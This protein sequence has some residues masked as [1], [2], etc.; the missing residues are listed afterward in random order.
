MTAITKCRTFSARLEHAVHA[1]LFVLG[2]FSST[3]VC[4]ATPVTY[5]GLDASRADLTNSKAA[6]NNFVAKLSPFAVED[7]EALGGESDPTILAG[8]PFAA[9]TD[10]DRVHTI[11]AFSVSGDHA[12]LDKGPPNQQAAG[13]NDWIQF[14]QPL[15]AFGSF[16][17]Q[18][19]DGLANT[20]TLRLTNT[21]LGTSKDVSLTL[22]PSAPF[23]NIFFFGVTD[24][25]PFD[26]VTMIETHDYDGI[27]LDDTMAGFFAPPLVSSSWSVD[28]AGDW[29]VAAN[30]TGGV[31]DEVGAAASF[32]DSISAPRTIQVD[33]LQTFG[34]LTFDNVQGYTIAGT[35]AL[36]LES[37]R[38]AWIHVNRGSHTISSQLS[39]AAGTTV[40]RR[41]LGTLTISGTQQHGAGTTLIASEGVTNLN[42]DAGG[43]LL[44]QADGEV[45][46][47]ST[48]HV[49][50]L[51]IGAG[52]TVRLVSASG[53]LVTPTL[54]IA[55]TPAVPTGTL[56][57]AESSAILDYTGDSPAGAIR[58]QILAGRGGAGLGKA[59]NGIGITSSAAALAAPESRSV[60]YA[61]NAL[62]PLGPVTTFRGQPVDETS[63]LIAYTRTGDANLD[64]VVD[65]DDVTIVGANYAP[66]FAKPRWDLGDFDYNG[67]VDN[68]DV[69]LLGAFYNPSA[70]SLAVVPEPATLGAAVFGVIVA[71]LMVRR[72]NRLNIAA[73]SSR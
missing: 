48:Q 53:T 66:G 49:R 21:S 72:S 27:L 38:P 22:G 17:A 45:N 26:R 42:T 47:A 44:L 9:Q 28:A 67:F 6:R 58:A 37:D 40:T 30:W 34:G 25:E 13:V 14:S 52:A 33:G 71:F 54:S 70:L 55:G 31:P 61:D 63:L 39:I 4:W 36:T 73:A 50:G 59:W 15:T 35:G 7:M 62:F 23:L 24:T 3:A 10:F 32:L 46:L 2:T 43:N 64:G 20:L 19:G 60:G 68:D 8:T 5:F 41:G 69:T 12:L 57:L 51:H 56:D 1:A 16:F 65:N 11:Y 18:G 29:S